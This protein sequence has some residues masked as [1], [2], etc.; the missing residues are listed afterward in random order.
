MLNL[1]VI[2][3]FEVDLNLGMIMKKKFL[4]KQKGMSLLEVIVSMLICGI[5][6]A[7]T[8]S[9]I[10]ASQRLAT[11]ADYRAIATREIQSIVDMMR[12]NR[13]GA[14]KYIDVTKGTRVNIN[15][16]SDA[17][18]ALC[19]DRTPDDSVNKPDEDT[20]RG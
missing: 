5:G 10:Q 13:L 8:I 4:R 16:N 3:V 7:G 1:S 9:A 2:K 12:A 11:S 15:G 19:K 18:L 20:P 14:D 6:L 17:G